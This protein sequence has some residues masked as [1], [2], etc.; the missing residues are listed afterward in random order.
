[1][2]KTSMIPCLHL[3]R[4]KKEDHRDLL[5]FLYVKAEV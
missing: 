5:L 1:M 2:Q 3:Y 4:N